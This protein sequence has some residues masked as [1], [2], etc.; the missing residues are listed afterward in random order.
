[1]KKPLCLIL[2]IV[3][4]L[5]PAGCSDSVKD[6]GAS[7]SG[8]ESDAIS[9]IVKAGEDDEGHSPTGEQ[10]SYNGAD[11][12][13]PEN[14]Y[15]MD[16]AHF[17]SR[18]NDVYIRYLFKVLTSTNWPAVTD[19]PNGAYKGFDL[20]E[21]FSS[22]MLLNIFF[23]AAEDY[24][25]TYIQGD[26]T[27]FV[28]PVEDIYAV[29]DKYFVNYKLDIHD[30]GYSF[31]YLEDDKYISSPGF[32]GIY[33]T[34]GF[35]YDISSVTDNGDGTVTVEI[36]QNK[37]EEVGYDFLPTD[38]CSAKHI[39]VIEPGENSCIVHSYKIEYTEG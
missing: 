35:F 9:E 2:A 27:H 31:T 12:S 32:I 5:V 28:I 29:L 11:T 17:V 39:F 38:E 6:G 22:Q 13:Y 18:E 30:V 34:V 36:L 33:P 10:A 14:L 7:T 25:G 4:M 15:V 24:S 26:S 37:V 23:T 21:D 8:E 16:T 1:M 19:V 20:G 3:L